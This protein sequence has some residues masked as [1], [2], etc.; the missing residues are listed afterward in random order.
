ML[1]QLRRFLSMF[2]KRGKM[3]NA[4]AGGPSNVLAE[5]DLTFISSHT[6]LSRS[7]HWHDFVL[8]I[9]K[10]RKTFYGKILERIKTFQ[11]EKNETV[12]RPGG[13]LQAR[14]GRAIWTLFTET[15]RW[16]NNQERIQAYDASKWNISSDFWASNLSLCCVLIWVIFFRS[17]IIWFKIVKS[18]G[19]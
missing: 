4:C 14:G 3:G 5:E 12:I 17:N 7:A 13:T 1:Q 11:T 15:S 9:V 18:Q 6:A 19:P 8:S 2:R 10:T 16:E